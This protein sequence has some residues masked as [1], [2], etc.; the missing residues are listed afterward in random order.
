MTRLASMFLC[1]ALL[2]SAGCAEDIPDDPTWNG[3]VELLLTANCGRCHGET[4]APGAPPDLRLDTYDDAFAFRERIRARAV[5]Y[6]E[7][8]AR[9]M[10]PDSYLSNDQKELLGIWIDN[11]APLGPVE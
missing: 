10:P 5:D 4:T 9:Q 7:T 1:S 2:A 3:E 8:G 11:G 6:E